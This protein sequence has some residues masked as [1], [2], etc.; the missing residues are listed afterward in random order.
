[1]KKI[2]YY[3]ASCMLL[4][5]GY[6]CSTD[7]DNYSGPKETL[8]GSVID[9][10]TGKPIQTEINDNGI[11]LK[12]MEYSWSDNPTPYYFNC[13]LDGTF[14]NTKI[15]KGDYSVT[16]FGPFVPLTEDKTDL[17]TIKGTVKLDFE[18]EP[19]LNVEWVGEPAY[20]QVANPT[21]GELENKISVQVKVTRGTTHPDYQEKVTDIALYI[22]SSSYYVGEG[23]NS[24]KDYDPRYTVRLE[25][26]AANNELG[27]VITLTTNGSFS[28][29]RDYYVRVGARINKQIEGSRRYNYNEPK[30]VEVL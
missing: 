18:V 5:G 15:F 1:M 17:V 6:A 25:G 29:N 24:T 23:T 21:T 20:I 22:N 13:M 7:I 3:I 19:F 28:P 8:K 4:I 11:R 10:N 30:K 9:K 14:N 2:I 26:D 16:P 12:L 27:N